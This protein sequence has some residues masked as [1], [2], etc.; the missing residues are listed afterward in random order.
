MLSNTK[1]RPVQVDLSEDVI[2]EIE[3]LAAAELLT[4]TA[5]VRRLLHSAVKAA[6]EQK[7]LAA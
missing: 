4:R 1:K 5:W 2:V 7:G 3:K 6:A